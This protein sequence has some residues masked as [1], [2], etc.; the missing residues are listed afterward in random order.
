ATAAE[1]NRD[2]RGAE[3]PRV[4]NLQLVM[5]SFQRGDLHQVVLAV[6]HNSKRRCRNGRLKADRQEQNDTQH[7]AHNFHTAGGYAA[8]ESFSEN[9]PALPPCPSRTR[10]ASSTAPAAAA[11]LMAGSHWYSGTICLTFARIRSPE[12]V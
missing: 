2:H 6:L 11:L 7:V 8:G 5:A 10:G 4:I 3:S 12:L 9:L 1:I